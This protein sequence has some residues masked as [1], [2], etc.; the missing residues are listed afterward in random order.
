MWHN[1][2]LLKKLSNCFFC[3]FFLAVVAGVGAW[4]LKKPVY[5]LQLV[6]VQSMDGKP[7]NHVNDMTVRNIAV[8]EIKGN[9]FTADLEEIRQ[10]FESVPWVHKASVR[11]EWPDKLIVSLEEHQPLGSWRDDGK[12]LSTKGEVF[13]VNMAEAEV[14]NKLKRFYGPDG[15]GKEVLEHY[16]EFRERLAEAN[17]V[18]VE[19]RLSDLYSWSVRMD[20]GMLVI[21]GR[22]REPRPLDKMMDRFL[23]IYPRLV[24]KFG[25]RIDRIDMRYANGVAVRL[26]GS[27]SAADKA[28]DRETEQTEEATQ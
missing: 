7:L 13:T 22:D 3:L 12:L 15:S 25:N 10:A 1:I 19:V 20:N 18:P 9:F 28:A 17:L 23:K 26:K 2:Q 6:K 16:W 14:D 27:A 21:F 5:A 24:Q 4:L 8:P 11:R